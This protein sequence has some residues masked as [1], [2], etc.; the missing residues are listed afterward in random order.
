M[1]YS[2]FWGYVGWAYLLGVAAWPTYG[3][4][5]GSAVNLAVMGKYCQLVIGPAGSG[6]STYCQTIQ[7]HCENEGRTVHVANLDPAAEEFGYT[8]T[9]G[10]DLTEM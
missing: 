2:S 6:K 7:Q 9:V 8:C 10:M 5:V 3:R 1:L 4:H